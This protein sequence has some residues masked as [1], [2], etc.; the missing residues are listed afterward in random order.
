MTI[1]LTGVVVLGNTPTEIM[2][3]FGK[4]YQRRLLRLVREGAALGRLA[5]AAQAE[6][7]RMT[8][9]RLFCL[10]F[11]DPLGECWLA[12]GRMTVSFACLSRCTN[13]SACLAAEFTRL[14]GVADYITSASFWSSLCRD[15]REHP[16]PST[17]IEAS[18]AA[19]GETP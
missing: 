8:K 4:V 5:S 3:A 15:S 10:A 13:P 17:R 19:S 16:A 14:R 11:A 7:K 18:N 12:P 2:R 1:R 6:D 9:A